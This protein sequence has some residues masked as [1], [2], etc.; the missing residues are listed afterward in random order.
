MSLV[1]EGTL[2]GGAAAV[3][4]GVKKV[5]ARDGRRRVLD[6]PF[7]EVKE[8]TAG[9]F[10]IEAVLAAA[11]RCLTRGPARP[12][13]SPAGWCP[14]DSRSAGQLGG[15]RVTALLPARDTR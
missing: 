3:G 12:E 7:A 9:Y 10:V 8:V 2:K 6:R 14:A 1:S 11:S 15:Y 5:R 13:S 4:R